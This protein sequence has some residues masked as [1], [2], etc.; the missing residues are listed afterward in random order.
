MPEQ[1]HR[2]A[3]MKIQILLNGRQINHPGRPQ[4]FRVISAQLAHHIGGALNHPHN[5]AFPHEHMVRLFREHKAAGAG[6]RV[7]ARFRQRRQL[8]LAVAVGEIGKHQIRQPVGSRFVERPQDTRPVGIAR[9][10]LQ[11]RLRFLPPIAPEISVQ[12]IHHRPQMP[13][14]LHIYLKQI[15]QVIQRRAGKPQSPLLLHRRRFGV[16]LGYNQPPQRRPILPRH[17]LPHRRPQVVAKGYNPFRFRFCQE[18]PPAVFRHLD[19]P[20]I[21]PPIGFNAYRS[22]QINIEIR[23]PIRP[24]FP[25]PFHIIG[26]PRLQSA[27]QTPVIGQPHIVG[28]SIRIVD[29]HNPPPV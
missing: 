9:M 24:H 25:P 8:I 4:P 2:H 14:F 22:P 17:F 19:K 26:L 20:E 10:P 3:V 29:V 7:E 28:D 27:L 5:P 21:G 16:A 6:Q 12:Q 13:P 1:I 18:N 23:R 15:P 11:H